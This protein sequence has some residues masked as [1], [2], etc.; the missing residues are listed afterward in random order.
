M[1]LQTII[2]ENKHK[3]GENEKAFN[4]LYNKIKNRG[5]AP[6]EKQNYL[7]LE[8]FATPAIIDFLFECLQEYNQTERIWTQHHDIQTLLIVWY[9]FAFSKDK[10]VYE[11]FES[12]MEENIHNINLFL[13]KLLTIG[14][15]IESKHFL[16]EKIQSYYDA[17]VIPFL[18]STQLIEK[19]RLDVPDEYYFHFIISTDG[20]WIYSNH[21]TEEE[22]KNRY[23]LEASV[24]GRNPGTYNRSYSINFQNGATHHEDRRRVIFEDGQYPWRNCFYTQTPKDCCS[25]PNLLDLGQLVNEL[26]AYFGIK[27][28]LDNIAYFTTVRGVKRK[29]IIDWIK[30]RFEFVS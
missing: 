1:Y 29:P 26:E 30:N 28:D 20:K 9:V 19:L 12:I 17:N 6:D 11:Y 5:Y 25:I 13:P 14:K 8:P 22:L 16:Y 4:A 7:K 21:D 27:F 18:P 23:I 15:Q 10:R 2:N 24:E 3:L